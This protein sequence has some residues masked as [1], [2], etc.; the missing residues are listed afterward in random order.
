MLHSGHIASWK[1]MNSVRFDALATI[2]MLIMHSC[3]SY[4]NTNIFYIKCNDAEWWK[5]LL[6][7]MHCYNSSVLRPIFKLHL[8]AYPLFTSC[9]VASSLFEKVM[10]FHSMK[11]QRNVTAH[12]VSPPVGRSWDYT[13]ID[14]TRYKLSASCRCCLLRGAV[15][16][17]QRALKWRLLPKEQRKKFATTMMVSARV[18]VL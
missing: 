12:T 1:R 11:P 5:P 7:Y 3:I 17:S 16:A 10:A 14:W 9:G 8:N 13:Q 18:P 6:Y 4:Y 2:K 15:K